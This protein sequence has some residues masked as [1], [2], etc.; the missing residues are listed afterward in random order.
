VAIY[1]QIILAAMSLIRAV[2]SGRFSRGPAGQFKPRRKGI[3]EGAVIRHS[4]RW[5]QHPND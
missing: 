5:M 2:R 3:K 1:R 4:L